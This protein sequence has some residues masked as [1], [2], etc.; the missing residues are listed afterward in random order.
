[1]HAFT[2][3]VSV[4]AILA[5]PALAQ[6]AGHGGTDRWEMSAADHAKMMQSTAANSYTQSEMRMHEKMMKAAG[7]D[8]SE[9]WVRKMIEH[10]RGAV[11]TRG[12]EP[13]SYRRNHLRA[14]P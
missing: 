8:P 4:A 2:I 5:A 14:P 10:H 7:A 11:D 12:I 3:A 9:T 6:H 13:D 1:M